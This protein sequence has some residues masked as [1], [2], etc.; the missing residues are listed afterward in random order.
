MGEEKLNE[1][2]YKFK[3]QKA[4]CVD[5]QRLKRRRKGYL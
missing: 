1:D 2:D 5:G 3:Q 4:A